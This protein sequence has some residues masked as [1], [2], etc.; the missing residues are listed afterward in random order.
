MEME[1]ERDFFRALLKAILFASLPKDLNIIAS[2]HIYM[3]QREHNEI[4]GTWSKREFQMEQSSLR[5]IC[6]KRHNLTNLSLL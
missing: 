1:K 3:E 2:I 4:K 6:Y 5:S